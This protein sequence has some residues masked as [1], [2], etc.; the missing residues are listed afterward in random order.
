MSGYQGGLYLFREHFLLMSIL[1][2]RTIL[3][4]LHR[5]LFNSLLRVLVL[6]RVLSR[7]SGALSYSPREATDTHTRTSTVHAPSTYPS[8]NSNLEH[9]EHFITVWRLLPRTHVR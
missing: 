5:A 3:A 1:L 8:P 6:V 4:L 9:H 7:Q 2:I